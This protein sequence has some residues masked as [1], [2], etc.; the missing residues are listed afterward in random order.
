MFQ[1]VTTQQ[2]IKETAATAAAIWRECYAELLGTAQIDYMLQTIQSEAAIHQ[3]IEEQGFEYYLVRLNGEDA[4][5]LALQPQNGNLLLSKVYFYAKNRGQG[6]LSDALLFAEERARH[7]R[8]N[9]LTLTVN[10][11]NNA[12]IGAYKK[13]GFEIYSDA[14]ADI[15]NGYVMDDFLMRRAL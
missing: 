6:L 8:C 15:G 9:A 2:Q 11:H 14:V 7:H 1:P 13:H 10:K 12:A 4:G 5:Y 3:Q